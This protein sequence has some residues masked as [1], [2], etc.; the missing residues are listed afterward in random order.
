MSVYVW[1][2]QA[3]REGIM[4]TIRELLGQDGCKRPPGSSQSI[5]SSEEA[6]NDRGAKGCREVKA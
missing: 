2:G 5:H 4:W 3:G 1:L 6:G